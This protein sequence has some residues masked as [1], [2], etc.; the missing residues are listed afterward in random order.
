MRPDSYTGLRA[1]ITPL[2]DSYGTPIGFRVELEGSVDTKFYVPPTLGRTDLGK[3]MTLNLSGDTFSWHRNES[4][5]AWKDCHSLVTKEILHGTPKGGAKKRR[6]ATAHALMERPLAFRLSLMRGEKSN[7][8]GLYLV[9]ASYRS[10]R[11]NEQAVSLDKDDIV[12][13][14]A[15]KVCRFKGAVLR[16]D[17]SDE[18][19]DAALSMLLGKT[20]LTSKLIKEKFMLY[21]F[22]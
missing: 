16:M 10:Q 3:E 1:S 17:P 5:S 9:A 19:R 8:I 20:L 4:S 15:P 18:Q 12:R 22:Y 11:L 14:T 13:M 6:E 21:Y 2:E 7:E